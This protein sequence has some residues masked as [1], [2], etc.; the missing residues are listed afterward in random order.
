MQILNNFDFQALEEPVKKEV[1]IIRDP[2]NPNQVEVCMDGQS[3]FVTMRPHSRKST[4]A[5]SKEGK[6]KVNQFFFGYLE[7]LIHDHFRFR[8]AFQKTKS[9]AA[10]LET[11]VH[12]NQK[13]MELDPAFPRP[14]KIMFQEM[15]RARISLPGIPGC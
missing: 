7:I 8:K 5:R 6:S 11:R 12:L 3:T 4:G 14:R 2:K 10:I 15:E 1:V 9:M 13:P